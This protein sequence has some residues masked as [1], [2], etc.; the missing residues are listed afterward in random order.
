MPCTEPRRCTLAGTTVAGSAVA[1]DT[2]HAALSQYSNCGA[3]VLY[4][5]GL[6]PELAKHF[7]VLSRR[8]AAHG[9]V[10]FT[11]HV[12]VSSGGRRTVT[13]LANWGRNRHGATT[14]FIRGYLLFIY[15]L[16]DLFSYLLTSQVIP[17][18]LWNPKALYRVYKC[19]HLF[20]S[21]ASSI[22]SI[23]PHPTFW[24]SILILSSHLRLGL[25]S[26]PFAPGFPTRTL[27]TS[28][29]PTYVL[30]KQPITFFLIWLP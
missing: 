12:A 18:I 13:E 26:G 3:S 10:W 15:W 6:W 23:I 14:T 25:L 24:L 20:L 7:L 21:W 11:V 19:P 1:Q 2:C 30:H 17:R 16:T 27:H 4:W 5:I 22:Q 29:L 28:L 9:T 8:S